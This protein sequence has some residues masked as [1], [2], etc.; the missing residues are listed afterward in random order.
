VPTIH[1]KIAKFEAPKDSLMPGTYYARQDSIRF[2]KWSKR[3]DYLCRLAIP[4]HLTVATLYG[5]D[6][7]VTHI[8]VDPVGGRYKLTA[9]ATRL[10][11][12]PGGLTEQAIKRPI[13]TR[14]DWSILGEPI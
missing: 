10:H 5:T 1:T 6:W 4:L 13:Y 3:F 9:E 11:H 8:H 7:L 2:V 12:T 14:A